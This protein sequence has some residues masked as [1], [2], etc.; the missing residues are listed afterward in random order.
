MI[1][2]ECQLPENRD[3]HVLFL[4]ERGPR[5]SRKPVGTTSISRLCSKKKRCFSIKSGG[6]FCDA[7]SEREKEE[8]GHEVV[9]NEKLIIED[10][11][12]EIAAKAPNDGE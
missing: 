1:W 11:H 6:G 10:P 12:D 7:D 5:P 8:K 2:R 9:G 3:C 4:F